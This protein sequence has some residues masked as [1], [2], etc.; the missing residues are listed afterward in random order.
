MDTGPHR[1]LAVGVVLAAAHT[2]SMPA[3]Q[4]W[5]M[6]TVASVTGGGAMSLDVDNQRWFRRL[7]RWVPDE[8]L[9]NGGPLQHRG[10]LH[11]WG[12]PALLAAFV[13]RGPT[14]PV[15]ASWALWGVVAGWVSHLIGDFLQGAQNPMYGLRA[16]IPL[17]PWWWHIGTGIPCGS[18]RAKT[19]NWTVYATT[20][21][22]AATLVFHA[23]LL[24]ST[25]VSEAF[26]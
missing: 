21:W 8:W 6:A 4:V 16:G 13:T 23:P 1:V 3:G 17:M 19:M 12:W 2:W 15:L 20:V 18:L 5:V 26:R 11:W 14:F 10:L 25:V 24:P 7:D 22:A 9:G